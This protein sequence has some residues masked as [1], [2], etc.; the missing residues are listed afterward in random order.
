MT[1]IGTRYAPYTFCCG[2][3]VIM[4]ACGS[5]DSDSS[6]HPNGTTI[7]AGAVVCPDSVGARSEFHKAIQGEDQIEQIKRQSGHITDEQLLTILETHKADFSAYGCSELESGVPVYIENEDAT[8]IATITAK[9]PD[10]TLL[11]GITYAQ[12]IQ[13]QKSK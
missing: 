7:L 8:G 3:I 13:F 10:E 11:H 12:E 4:A 1:N 9:L 2:L 5:P 6:F